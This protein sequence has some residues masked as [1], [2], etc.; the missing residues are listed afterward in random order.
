MIRYIASDLDG[1]L[2]ADGAQSIA[3]EIFDLILKLR[4][5]GIRFIAASGRQYHSIRRLFGPVKD[6]ISYITENG[7]LC[8]HE[9][10]VVSR[11]LIGRELGLEIIGAG[12]E[13]GDCHTLLSCE[14]RHY[15]DSR[16]NAFVHHMRDVLHNDIAVVD[17]LCQVE[18]PF[19][20]LAICD[21]QGT[22]KLDPF[23]K[24]RFSDRIRVVTAGKEWVDFLAPDADKGKALGMLLARLGIPAKEGIAF[25]DQY[26]DIEMLRFAGIGY[27]MKTAAPGVADYADRVTE[28]VANVL[29]EIVETG[30][31]LKAV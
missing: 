28:S 3:P 27:A 2:L 1:T 22:Q 26:N 31:T 20:K 12:R 25:G 18:E 5:Q 6:M 21:F 13:Y 30:G 11:G 14:S 19:L 7:S 9:G 29:R 10:E 4:E 17:D 8:I 24:E 23:L 15:T 16:N